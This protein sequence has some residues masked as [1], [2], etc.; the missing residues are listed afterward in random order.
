MSIWVKTKLSGEQVRT[1]SLE[2]LKAL[3]PVKEK[4]AESKT[5]LEDYRNTLQSIRISDSTVFC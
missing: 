3:A 1:M 4:L 2:V 5:K